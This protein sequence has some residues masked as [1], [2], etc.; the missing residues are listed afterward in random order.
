MVSRRGFVKR[1][2]LLLLASVSL[3]SAGRIFGRDVAEYRGPTPHDL[4]PTDDPPAQI[5]F[6][7]A[8]FAP[9]VN[10]DFRI[11]LDPSRLLNAKLVSITDI[12]PVPD[13]PVAGCESFVLK[14]YGLEA[15]SRQ[16]TYRV[17][18]ANLG[19]FDL[20]LV[21]GDRDKSKK[22]YYYLAVINRLN[23]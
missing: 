2:G 5:S 17:E 12:G 23:G 7:K 4:Q 22:G 8:T 1:G 3:G 13:R 10:T 11:Y 6:T 16:S 9:Y 14:F 18:H 20:F 19:R 15:L 21:P